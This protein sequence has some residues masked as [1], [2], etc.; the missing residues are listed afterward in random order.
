MISVH[1]RL[2]AVPLILSLFVNEALAEDYVPKAGEF[3]P[4]E[5][6]HYLTGELVFVDHVNRM[7]AIRLA[8]DGVSYRYHRAPSHQFAMLPFGS[9]RYHGAAANLRDIPIG[10]NLHGYFYLPPRGNQQIPLPLVKDPNAK[11]RSKYTHAISLEDDVSFYQR[12]GRLWKIEAI[13][14]EARTLDVVSNGGN[15]K[16]KSKD[17]LTGK[18][19]FFIDESTRVWKGRN[20]A[21]L[22]DVAIGQGVQLNLTWSPKWEYGQY[23]CLDIWTDAA[24]LQ[25]AA[26]R[27]R[28]VHV[29]HMKTRWLPGWVDSVKH[30]G[31]GKGTVTLT[32][33][34]GMDETLY[35]DFF[36]PKSTM[37]LAPAEWTLRSWWQDHDGINAATYLG[38]IEVTRK[39]NPPPGSSGI[40]ITLSPSTILE[41]FRPGRIVRIRHREWPNVKL[42]PE[43]R[44]QNMSE[45]IPKTFHPPR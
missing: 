33:F 28:R 29:R 30:T 3:P 23:H 25:V 4:P 13:D 5:S 34:G 9:L 7:A 26:E 43:E 20:F 32:L 35:A 42:P 27:Q 31:G 24:S 21:E 37:K 41:G 45:R 17:G 40:Q 22:E 12:Q 10:T 6:S 39:E 36:G 38:P 8:G 14:L 1:Q 16:A 2:L 18:Q 15:D 44:I 19:T 11:Y